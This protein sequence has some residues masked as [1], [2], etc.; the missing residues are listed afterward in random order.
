MPMLAV[1][2]IAI[3]PSLFSNLEFRNIGP[4][5]G[6]LTISEALKHW[7]YP[8]AFVRVCWARLQVTGDWVP[9][10]A[11]RFTTISSDN[12]HHR[13]IDRRLLPEG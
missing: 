1:V 8:H 11:N 9:P 2:L 13:S 10:A 12:H 3:S 7:I 5:S 4:L 6:A